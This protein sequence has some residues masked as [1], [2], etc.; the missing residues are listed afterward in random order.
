M[1]CIKRMVVGIFADFGTWEANPIL[2]IWDDQYA[3]SDSSSQTFN[4]I[5]TWQL[6]YRERQKMR[7]ARTGSY[8]FCGAAFLSNSM[9]E[10]KRIK[11]I[12][13][14]IWLSDSAVISYNILVHTLATC[15][16]TF[17]H[18]MPY[19]LFD[20]VQICDEA[21]GGDCWYWFWIGNITA[22]NNI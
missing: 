4:T 13:A 12:M 2:P 19:L 16:Q 21:I 8:Q 3:F 6:A 10:S 5:H 14:Y 15:W 9:R 20:E 18:I 7:L 22:I 17:W 1:W 11:R